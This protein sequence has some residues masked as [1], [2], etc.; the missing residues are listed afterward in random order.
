MMST[1]YMLLDCPGQDR[2]WEP[3][4][5][6]TLRGAKREA[7]TAGRYDYEDSVIKIAVGDNISQPRRLVSSK[8]NRP[9]ERWIDHGI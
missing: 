6:K 3:C 8:L 9:E 4:N 2:S 7:T 1:Y 5:A